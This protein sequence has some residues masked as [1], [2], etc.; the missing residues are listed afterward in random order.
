[1][2]AI[3]PNQPWV[4][5]IYEEMAASGVVDRADRFSTANTSGPTEAFREVGGFDEGFTG[6]GG[7]DTELGRPVRGAGYPIRSDPDAR[8]TDS[9]NLTLSEFCANNVSAGRTLP[10]II[11]L[12]P[13]L[14]DVLLPVDGDGHRR[15][16]RAFAA[17]AYRAFPLR[18]P[19][20]Y[21]L[22]ASAACAV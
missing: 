8:A 19:T 14:V 10:R 4:E 22:I 12:H 7:E 1:P 3:A 15:G 9:Q 18:S 17:R 6:W 21:R 5:R 20:A 2:G 11:G 13:E 16:L